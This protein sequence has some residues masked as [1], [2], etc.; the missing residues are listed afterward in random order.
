[1]FCQRVLNCFAVYSCFIQMLHSSLHKVEAFVKILDSCSS[2]T[3]F[4]FLSINSSSVYFHPVSHLIFNNFLPRHPFATEA[5]RETWCFH[6]YYLCSFLAASPF[7][8]LSPHHVIRYLVIRWFPGGRYVP[9]QTRETFFFPF[10]RLSLPVSLFY[11]MG[12]LVMWG[13]WGRLLI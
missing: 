13:F 2:L 9:R 8:H 5:P 10:I 12:Y 4:F 3:F 1:M 6:L 11:L 7:L